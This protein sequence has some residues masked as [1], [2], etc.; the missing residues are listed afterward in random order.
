[1]KQ[2]PV[3]LAEQEV[4]RRKIAAVADLRRVAANSKRILS[5]PSVIAGACVGAVVLGY[6]ATGRSRI[7]DHRRNNAAAWSPVLSTAQL[8]VPLIRIMSTAQRFRRVP[9]RRAIAAGEVE[10][11]P[12]PVRDR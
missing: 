10:S 1:M 12:V 9:R 7:Q 4:V 8:L 3:A 6:L 5:S 2:D 11:R